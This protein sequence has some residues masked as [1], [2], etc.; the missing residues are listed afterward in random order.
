MQIC[1]AIKEV[2]HTWNKITPR[3]EYV[4]K[5]GF[6]HQKLCKRICDS[7]TLTL[8]VPS[9]PQGHDG[10]WHEE[11]KVNIKGILERETAGVR[12]WVRDG[13]IDWWQRMRQGEKET[14]RPECQRIVVKTYLKDGMSVISIQHHTIAHPATVISLWSCKWPFSLAIRRLLLS[15]QFAHKWNH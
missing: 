12:V 6:L 15:I 11:Q 7:H 4:F 13:K 1:C 10:G 8:P 14:P 3:T 9:N 2:G 5:M